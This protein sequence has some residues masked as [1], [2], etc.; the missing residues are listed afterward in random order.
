M[1]SMRAR[2]PRVAVCALAALIIAA[3]N[4]PPATVTVDGVPLTYR[5]VL[6]LTALY[7][8][9]VGFTQR[10]IIKQPADMPKAAPYVYYAGRDAKG[11]PIVW[12]ST[13]VH[14]PLPKTLSAAQQAEMMRELEDVGVIVTLQLGQGNADLRRVYEKVKNDPAGLTSLGAALGRAMSQM[15]ARTVQYANDERRWIFAHVHAGTPRSRAEAMLHA[16]GLSASEQ[17]HTTV[18]SL[19]GAFEPG[20]YFSRN[21]T[22]TFD[23]YKRL[24]KIDLSQPIP[25]CL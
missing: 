7:L 15:S 25:D 5:D 17:G 16:H 13:A 1:R 21:V 12:V 18:V 19:P 8:G 3:G 24:Y 22:L 23:R 10:G 14:D 4:E 6:Q 9:S 11:K 20:C 2:I